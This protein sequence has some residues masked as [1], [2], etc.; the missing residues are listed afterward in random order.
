[1]EVDITKVKRDEKEASR[2]EILELR[3][4]MERTFDLKSEALMSR[5][6]NAIERL[7]KQQEVLSLTAASKYMQTTKHKTILSFDPDRGKGDLCS[8]TSPAERNRICAEPRD[9]A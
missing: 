3:R 2:R 8:K 6:K 5:E 9:G 7:Q 4:D 1:M